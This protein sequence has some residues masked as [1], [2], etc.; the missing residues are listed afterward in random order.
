ML[1]ASWDSKMRI[2]KGNNS[3]RQKLYDSTGMRLQESSDYCTQKRK[4]QWWF[5]GPGR[6]GKPVLNGLSVS[7]WEG[8]HVLGL[9]EVMAAQQSSRF[10]DTR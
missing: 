3:V 7:V 4:A 2:A 5:P 10:G 1:S 8:D 6:E 9:M